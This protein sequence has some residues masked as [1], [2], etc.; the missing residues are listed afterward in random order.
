MNWRDMFS[1]I[2]SP[3]P[4]LLMSV[5]QS[6]VF[7]LQHVGV[8]FSLTSDAEEVNTKKPVA[9][10]MAIRAKVIQLFFLMVLVLRFDETIGVNVT[11]N[12]KNPGSPGKG[13]LINCL[14]G[15]ME[16]TKALINCAPIRGSGIPPSIYICR[17]AS[18]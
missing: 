17:K 9:V 16:C 13:L 11:V 10:M 4:V 6:V 8:S 3:L 15:A 14:S 7:F 12:L 1:M 18:I 5:P 2:R